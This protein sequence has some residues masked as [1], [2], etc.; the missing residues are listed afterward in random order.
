VS[1]VEDEQ[2]EA[3]QEVGEFDAVAAKEYEGFAFTP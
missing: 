2:L 3:D 1:D